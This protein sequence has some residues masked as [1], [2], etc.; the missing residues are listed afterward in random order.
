VDFAPHFEAHGFADA[1]RLRGFVFGASSDFHGFYFTTRFLEMEEFDYG[2][3]EKLGCF[4][5]VFFTGINETFERV[6]T[7][8]PN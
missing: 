2:L 5:M 4:K 8:L 1:S 7:K 6:L 3:L